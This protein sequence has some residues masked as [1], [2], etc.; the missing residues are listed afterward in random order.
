MQEGSYRDKLYCEIAAAIL[1]FLED[2]P[3]LVST[4]VENVIPFET[5]SEVRKTVLVSLQKQGLIQIAGTKRDAYYKRTFRR[6]NVLHICWKF[7]EICRWA[8]GRDGLIEILH[9]AEPAIFPDKESADNT[10]PTLPYR[11][12]TKETTLP[13]EKMLDLQ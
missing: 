1:G 2:H 10:L 11:K 6:K 13:F 7:L 3:K 8:Y 5:P 12:K 4:E 9:S